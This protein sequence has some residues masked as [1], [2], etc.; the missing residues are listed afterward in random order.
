VAAVLGELLEF[1]SNCRPPAGE[2]NCPAEELHGQI[3]GNGWYLPDE[4]KV[5]HETNDHHSVLTIRVNKKT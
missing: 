2:E 1:A 4:L 5:R 3:V